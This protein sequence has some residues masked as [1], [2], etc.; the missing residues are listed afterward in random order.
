MDLNG[1]KSE[2]LGQDSSLKRSLSAMQCFRFSSS[3]NRYAKRVVPFSVGQLDTRHIS[4]PHTP[5]SLL[6]LKKKQPCI[7]LNSSCWYNYINTFFFVKLLAKFL[8]KSGNEKVS[9]KVFHFFFFFFFI[10]KLTR[11]SWLNSIT[12]SFFYDATFTFVALFNY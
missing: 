2:I 4:P 9:R 11:F 5:S 6:T 3:T 7:A 10:C 8:T 1:I 12:F